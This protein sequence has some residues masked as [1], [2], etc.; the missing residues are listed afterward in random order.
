M[1]T[2]LVVVGCAKHDCGCLQ[3]IRCTCVQALCIVT[4]VGLTS[5][6]A[7]LMLM[8]CD[9]LANKSSMLSHAHEC[10]WW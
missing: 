1:S 5:A 2:A 10:L 3:Y 4:F 9:M 8:V 7:Q 6:L